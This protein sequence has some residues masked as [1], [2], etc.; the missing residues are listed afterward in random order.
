MTTKKYRCTPY[1]FAT[2]YGLLGKHT[3]S[4]G[5]SVEFELDGETETGFCQVTLN[6]YRY[7]D[8][9]KLQAELEQAAIEYLDSNLQQ[10]NSQNEVEL[11]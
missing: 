9:K 1:N 3:Y 4:G 5:I 6:F 11:I 2:L 7:T 10:L 8:N